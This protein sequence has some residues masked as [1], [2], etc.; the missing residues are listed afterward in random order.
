MQVSTTGQNFIIHWLMYTAVL[1]V[2]DSCLWILVDMEES[3]PCGVLEGLLG[4]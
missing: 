2:E 4:E 1:P 3:E